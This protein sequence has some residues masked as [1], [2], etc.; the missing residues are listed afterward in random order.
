MK[1]SFLGKTIKSNFLTAA[2]IL[3]VSEKAEWVI[4][5]IAEEDVGCIY[6]FWW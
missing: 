6:L 1:F 2:K 5:E 3:L 4:K